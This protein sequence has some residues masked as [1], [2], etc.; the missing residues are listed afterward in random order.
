MPET[1]DIVR[2]ESSKGIGYSVVDLNGTRHVFASAVPRKGESLED[3]AHD[4]LRTIEAVMQEEGTMGSIVKQAVFV[5]GVDEIDQCRQIIKE[6]YRD[7]LPATTYIPQPPCEGKL[8]EIEAFGIGWGRGD[9]EIKR[10]SERTVLTRHDDIT[11]VHLGHIIPQTKAA[12]VYQRSLD[13]FGRM[14]EGL[15]ARGFRYDQV[16]RTW[17]YLGDI[18]GREGDTQRYKELNRART[19]FYRDIRFGG[20]HLPTNLDHRVYPASTGIGADGNDVVMSC[21]AM[22]TDRDD[23]K[24]LPLENPLQTSAFD[25]GE[26]YSPESPKFARAMAIAAGDFATI[27]V[28]GT[29]SI[30][31]SETRYLGDMEGQTW[32]TLEN[33]AALISADNFKAHGLPG[34]GATLDDLAFVRVYVKRQED[35]ALSKNICNCRLGELPAIYAAADVCRPE[36]LVEIEGI[37]FS[38]RGVQ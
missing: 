19:D 20:K 8:L 3:Q 10:L 2:K 7:Q 31:Q 30:T 12:G 33:I 6:F 11:W 34:F 27:F 4:A 16:V 13:A 15:A 5:K 14:S 21:I 17:L 37:A 23:V 35:Y 28:S 1:R 25:Y 22:T 29:A 18:V 24:L 32:Q 9:V 38:R 36:L 26:Q